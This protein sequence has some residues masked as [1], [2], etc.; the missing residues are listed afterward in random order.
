M[1][2]LKQNKSKTSKKKKILF[3]MCIKNKLY[4]TKNI[5]Q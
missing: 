4:V 5:S 1:K 3:K 2:N